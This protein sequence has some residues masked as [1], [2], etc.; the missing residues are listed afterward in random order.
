MFTG[1]IRVLRV[2]RATHHKSATKV[3]AATSSSAD[4][5]VP[6]YDTPLGRPCLTVGEA[7]VLT[8]LEQAGFVA[9][10]FAETLHEIQPRFGIA[11]QTLKDRSTLVWYPT[12]F[13]NLAASPV[14]KFQV[15]VPSHRQTALVAGSTKTRIVAS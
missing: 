5:D 8:I 9:E 6:V 11:F 12:G 1:L 4:T 2:L 3:D 13:A 15:L 14:Q 10:A 7:E